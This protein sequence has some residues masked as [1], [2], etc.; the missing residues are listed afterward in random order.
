MR[1]A[2]LENAP[3]LPAGFHRAPCPYC[4]RGDRDVAVRITAH[5]DGSADWICFRCESK[6]KV[7]SAD[8]TGTALKPKP[9]PQRWSDFAERLWNRALQL[10][11]A[12]V[13]SKYLAVRQCRAPTAADVRWMDPSPPKDQHPCMAALV[14]DALTGAPMSLQRTW[15]RFDGTDKADVERQR[16]FLWAHAKAGGV[17]RLDEHSGVLGVAE[18]IETALSIDTVPMWAALDAGNLQGFPVLAGVRELHIFADNDANGVG[19]KAA[20]TLARRWKAAGR[21]VHLYMP[22]TVGADFNDVARERA[23]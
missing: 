1:R 2:T 7:G 16:Q 23:A 17:V 18:G 22:P 13:A 20:K 3:F 19:L 14:T 21:A 9:A 12:D 11:G 5:G 15:L 4:N 10:T 8:P 6:G